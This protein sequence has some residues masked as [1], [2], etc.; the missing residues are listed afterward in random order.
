MP[1]PKR[2]GPQVSAIAPVSVQEHMASIE[3]AVIA[4]ID[5]GERDFKADTDTKKQVCSNLDLPAEVH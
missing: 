2:R 5:A 4:A 1:S 3:K